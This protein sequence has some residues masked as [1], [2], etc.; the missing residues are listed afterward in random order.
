M[1]MM[2]YRSY[3]EFVVKPNLASSPEV[4]ISFLH[5]MSKMVRPRADEVFCSL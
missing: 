4:V 5:E 2:G 1:Q 3:A